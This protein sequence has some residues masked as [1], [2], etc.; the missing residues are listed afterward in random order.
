VSNRGISLSKKWQKSG[1]FLN[2]NK[3]QKSGK[4]IQ[5]VAKKVA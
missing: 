4:K 3:W 5:K 2:Q 1:I